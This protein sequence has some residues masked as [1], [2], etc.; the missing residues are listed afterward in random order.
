[1]S[2][3]ASGHAADALEAVPLRLALEFRDPALEQD[4]RAALSKRAEVRLTS[5]GDADMT[6]T[7]DPTLAS[8]RTI[9]LDDGTVAENVLRPVDAHLVPEAA[10]LVAAGYAIARASATTEPTL[11]RY[12]L[13]SRE[14]EVALLLLDGTSN[15]A[16]ARVLHISVHTAKFHVAALLTKLQA[17]NRA[18]AVAVI[19][20]EGLVPV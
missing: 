6:I 2:L 20:R 10:R 12:G 18:D 11:V 16:I 4:V 14:R 5:R 9:V 3:S 17:R 8:H 19:L 1:M 15:K 13:T 7:D